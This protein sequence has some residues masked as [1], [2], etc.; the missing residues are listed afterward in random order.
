MA[1]PTTGELHSLVRQGK[2]MPGGRYYIRNHSDVTN[3][4]RAVGRAKPAT[5]QERNKVR[6]HIIRNAKRIGAGHLIP[7]TWKS[8]GELK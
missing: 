3:A 2:A 6:R 1:R 4:V 7:D 8:T 5:T